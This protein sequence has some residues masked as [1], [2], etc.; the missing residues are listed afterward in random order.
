M[1]KKMFLSPFFTPIAVVA[2]WGA[3]MVVMHYCFPEIFL[4]ITEDGELIEHITHF[5]Y[6]ALIAVLMIVCA[7]YKDKMMTWGMFLFL[8]MTAFLREQGIQHHLSRTDTTPFKSRFFL[9]P[10]NPLSEKIIFG[11]VLLIVAGA[12]L[13]LA[14]KY[15]KHL[16]VSFFHFNTITWSIAVL[17]VLGVVAKIVD[18]FPSNYRKAHGQPLP[19][20]VYAWFQMIEESGEMLLPYIAIVALYQ[21]HLAHRD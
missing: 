20:D 10:N 9:N 15:T 7:D 3:F 1:M 18:R 14:I 19:E 16:V 8:A 2:V 21:Y 11:L 4:Q 17:C 6:V 13:Y 12:V 5:G